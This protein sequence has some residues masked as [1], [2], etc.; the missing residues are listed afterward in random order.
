[1]GQIAKSAKLSNECVQSI[2]ND[3]C[4]VCNRVNI[5]LL[6]ASGDNIVEIQWDES[7]V[8]EGKRMHHRGKRPNR[9]GITW[10]AG[11]RI[12]DNEGAKYYMA[13]IVEARARKDLM[14]II[15]FISCKGMKLMT[16]KWAAYTTARPDD[17]DCKDKIACECTIHR[18]V[19][20]S[21][22]FV[23]PDG[24]HSNAAEGL[25]SRLKRMLRDRWGTNKGSLG[26]LN[27][28]LQF[29]LTKM[30]CIANEVS[31]N[32]AIFTF[33]SQ[34]DDII[35][36]MTIAKLMKDVDY[37]AIGSKADELALVHNGFVM[38]LNPSSDKDRKKAKVNADLDAEAEIAMAKIHRDEPEDFAILPNRLVDPDGEEG[39]A[40][41]VPALEVPAAEHAFLDSN[42][43]VLVR[44]CS[45]GS[46]KH[47]F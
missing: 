11:G 4:D 9:R 3:V 25:W 2:V 24:T 46:T 30:N 13:R 22:K 12:V 26:V 43:C 29:C 10:I 32:C 39:P 36:V 42:P 41:E 38:N 40:V 47:R 14:P 23:A 21:E 8:A 35:D 15:D 44:S 34:V 5:I 20:H 37:E 28:H 7:A 18:S 31:P 16:D 19:N 17:C 27:G 1:M 45:N 6:G 33:L